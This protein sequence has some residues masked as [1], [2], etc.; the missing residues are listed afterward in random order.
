MLSAIIL[1]QGSLYIHVRLN[2]PR[3]LPWIDSLAVDVDKVIPK[4]IVTSTKFIRTTQSSHPQQ[5]LVLGRRL[6]R[7]CSLQ[8]SGLRVSVVP[9]LYTL[10][11]IY[12]NYL[13][14]SRSRKFIT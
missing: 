4:D 2:E 10:S 1:S 7:C 3:R 9:E 13:F 14:P 5:H 8:P 11:I 12:L 6:N